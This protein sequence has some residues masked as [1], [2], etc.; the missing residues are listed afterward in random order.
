LSAKTYWTNVLISRRACQG[1]LPTRIWPFETVFA[2]PPLAVE[3]ERKRAAGGKHSPDTVASLIFTSG[4]TGA[5]KGVML[6]HRNFTFHGVRAAAHLRPGAHRRMLS[7][8]PFAPHLRVL[9][10]LLVPLAPARITTCKS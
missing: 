2:L 1:R 6:T 9:H 10:R 7:V 3:E 5:P 4:T 8:L